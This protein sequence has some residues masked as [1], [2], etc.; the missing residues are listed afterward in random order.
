MRLTSAIGLTAAALTAVLGLPI[1]A[2]AAAGDTLHVDRSSKAC[3]D[4]GPGS[5]AQP[6][7]S[8][9]AAAAAAEPGQ[10]VRIAAGSYAEDLRIT[11]SGTEKAP[12]TFVGNNT[13][14]KAAS[15][16]P[17][18]ALT[19]S[20]AHDVVFRSLGL[21]ETLIENSDRITLDRD[22][23]YAAADALTPL[24]EVTGASHDVA[25]TRNHLTSSRFAAFRVSG[26][27]TGT[28]ISGNTVLRSTGAPV[29]VDAAPGTTVTNN[30]LALGCGPG[31]ALTGGSTGAN[32]YNN[33][34]DGHSTTRLDGFGCLD[35]G[36]ATEILV[37]ADSAP[38]STADYNLVR[39]TGT[40]A[41]YTW[42]GQTYP[43]PEAFHAA[44]G[45]GKNDL[46]G[47]PKVDPW[48]GRPADCTAVGG[49]PDKTTCSPAIDSA[50][51]DA[52]GVLPVDEDGYPPAD[53][54]YVD[55]PGP[56]YL[57]R[58]AHEVQDELA[59]NAY[60]DADLAQAPYGT[61][62]TFTARVGHNWTTA[63]L[64]YTY[65]FGDGTTETTPSATVSH[66]YAA[67]CD[68]RPGLTVTA[69]NGRQAVGGADRI[70]ITVPGPLSAK[71]SA[72]TVVPTTTGSSADAP[73]T[74]LADATATAADSPW[75]ITNYHYDFGD[76]SWTSDLSFASLKHTYRAPGDYTVSLTVT[77][78][79][80]RTSST[81]RVFHAAY[82]PGRYTAVTPTRV[83]DTRTNNFPVGDAL[84]RTLDL[85]SLSNPAN[86][87]LSAGMTAVVMNVTATGAT[88]D[89]Y[90]T[91]WPSGQPRPASSNLNI[92]AGQTV[93]N[94]V[95]VPVGYLQSVDIHNHAGQADVIVDVVGYYQPE[96]GN[97]FT[98]TGPDRLLDTRPSGGQ[99]DLKLTQGETRSVQVTGK[100]G[101]P[102]G[103]SAVVLNLTSTQSTRGGYLAAYP[104]GQNRPAVSSLNF[105]A[106]QTV[107]NQAIVPIGW[108]GKIDL[109]NFAGDTQ[110]ILDVF[111]YYR[112]DG[113]AEFTPV[114][115]TRLTDTRPNNPLGA[116][117]QLS[118]QVGGANGVPANATAA[119]LN[120]TATQ[121]TAGSFLTVWPDGATRPT[122]SNLNF[123]AGQ[124]VPNHV[125][126]PLGAN[127]RVDVYNL[128]G[129]T[130]VFADLFGY[131]TNS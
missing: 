108:D 43:T 28:T 115:P 131:F 88:Q 80:K 51:A 71:L 86:R 113:K 1:P 59:D 36:A 79:Q 106:G 93:A 62:V 82:Q 6:Y 47:D 5:E 100:A 111:G 87:E 57:D 42:A 109:Y 41:P 66:T 89:T 19:V 13:E 54:P 129:T 58:G 67:P 16:R 29:S 112:Y 85:S 91:I 68:C 90:L 75:P 117:G 95:T 123:Q 120:V 114:A 61:K 76:G 110:V 20:G 8:I 96:A 81:S 21:G 45:Q 55:N 98:P 50:K 14:L 11:R 46:M 33:I 53:D 64:G 15:P 56:G 99:P 24:I 107:A 18:R 27:A 103:A 32:I 121:P 63:P 83:L 3:S 122:T 22:G 60:L 72:T 130:H 128:A 70:R 101:V 126:T 102:A 119:V 127:G 34:V 39:A 84:P 38:G 17:A 31:I 116:N 2:V 78:S 44:T 77:D 52:P 94:L 92:K 4:S 10:T 23:G 118:M 7:C 97:R 49:K 74:V 37:S 73:F 105:T 30:T 9:G 40:G 26:G 124:T 65:D 12:I 35:G 104:H 69:A 125:I 48:S 25:L